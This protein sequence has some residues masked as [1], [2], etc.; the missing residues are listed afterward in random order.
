MADIR[1][2]ALATT[3]TTPASDDYLALDGAAQG[4]RK[5]LATNIAN[6]VTDVILGSSGP[7]VKSSLSARAPRQGLVFDGSSAT[8]A[9]VT[10]PAPKTSFTIA[11]WANPTTISSVQGVLL[12]SGSLAGNLNISSGLPAIF[13]GTVY[14]YSSASAT[15][16]K[17]DFWAYVLSGGTGTWY[18]NGVAAGSD[19]DGGTYPD[20]IIAIGVDAGGSKFNGYLFPLVYNRALSASEVVAL[21]EAGAPAGADYNSASNTGIITGQN[22]TFNGGIGNWTSGGTGTVAAGTNVMNCTA[23]STADNLAGYLTFVNAGYNPKGYYVRVTADITNNSGTVRIGVGRAV[24][25]QIGSLA[26]NGTF[27][28]TAF[29][30]ATTDADSFWICGATSSQTFTVD[31]F[32]VFRLGLL[33]APDAAQAGGGLVWYDTSGN[34]ANISWTSGVS[35][36]VP[37][38]AKVATGWAFG[39]DVGIGTTSPEGRL[40]LAASASGATG[41]ILVLDNPI[42]SALNNS[43]QIAFLNDVG[44]S[45]AGIANVRLKSLTTNAGSGSSAFTIT[46]FDGSSEAE[47][48]RVFANGNFGIGTGSTDGGQKLQVNGTAYV[49]G[50][51]TVSGTGANTFGTTGKTVIQQLAG[52]GALA[53]GGWIYGL[54]EGLNFSPNG[55]GLNKKLVMAYFD[56]SA[57]RSALEFSNVSSGTATLK[58]SDYGGPTTVG[59]TLAVSGAIAIGNTVQTAVA[60]ASTHKVT[61]SIGGST[62][63]LLATNV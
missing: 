34:A 28:A 25:T 35:W 37:S 29:L 57:Y 51:I 59:G 49:S 6:N 42:A 52:S 46:T 36:N 7:S 19:S 14:K 38:S 50:N 47:R 5:I 1:I 17:T 61:I 10:I 40:H 56:G 31:N 54:D 39:G 4:T 8:G 15:A 53:A 45:Y 44:A 48:V 18:K 26:G 32:Q 9:T 3:A 43:N 12:G 22:N 2:N 20:A 41:S 30:P 24:L 16:G 11:F 13:N 21:Y 33:L 58:L 23:G 27:D 63:Y 55:A 60:V 62:Y